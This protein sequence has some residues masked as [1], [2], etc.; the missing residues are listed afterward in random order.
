MSNPPRTSGRTTTTLM[1]YIPSTDKMPTTAA[2]HLRT[3]SPRET[4]DPM[5]HAYSLVGLPEDWRASM[6]IVLPGTMVYAETP[7]GSLINKWWIY[8]VA[9]A[10]IP[11]AS[12]EE[13]LRLLQKEGYTPTL[14]AS[15]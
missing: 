1:V 14:S 5:I 3:I 7:L 2:G 10:W 15:E 4:R 13:G 6:P 11:V 12:M 9:N 8:T